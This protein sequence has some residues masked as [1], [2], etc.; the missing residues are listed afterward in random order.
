MSASLY[1]MWNWFLLK[2]ASLC[3]VTYS[4]VTKPAPSKVCR[5]F[6]GVSKYQ[7]MEQ[8]ILEW[9]VLGAARIELRTSPSWA[10]YANH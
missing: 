5:S 6:L 7:K 3:V 4:Y 10:I 8:Q 9:K 2:N 1:A